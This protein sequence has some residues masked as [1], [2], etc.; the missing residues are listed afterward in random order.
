[1]FGIQLLPHA[2]CKRLGP[3]RMRTVSCLYTVRQL[4]SPTGHSPS[5]EVL[6]VQGTVVTAGRARAVVVCTGPSTAMGKIRY[7]GA[8]QV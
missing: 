8:A 3:G 1:M 5:L 2:L 7:G 6:T 4:C